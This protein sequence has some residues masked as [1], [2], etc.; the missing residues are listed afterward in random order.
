MAKFKLKISLERA[1]AVDD[2][3][4]EPGKAAKAFSRQLRITALSTILT[5]GMIVAVTVAW[6]AMNR[7]VST[8]GMQMDIETSSVDLV[9]AQTK[10]LLAANNV[11]NTTSFTPEANLTLS[12]AT[13]NWTGEGNTTG[14]KFFANTGYIDKYTGK[15]SALGASRLN[16]DDG[17]SIV[18]NAGNANNSSYYRV[19]DVWIGAKGGELEASSDMQWQLNA[20]L[21][22]TLSPD[23]VNHKQRDYQYAASVDF[24]ID[25]VSEAN[26]VGTLDLSHLDDDDPPEFGSSVNIYS[27]Y[28]GD[29]AVI[30]QNTDNSPIHVYMVF[31][32]DGALEQGSA[33]VPA[34]GTADAET[35]YYDEDGVEQTDIQEGDDVSELYIRQTVNYVRTFNISTHDISLLIRFEAVEERT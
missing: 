5:L 10:P 19:Y 25:S 15:V 7:D 24:Y 30:P 4:V 18:P 17:L 2:P 16:G 28:S 6:F 20:M 1:V 34:S 29:K 9:I 13:N 27:K 8:D 14:L 33:L 11:T 23:T 31:Y 35:T 12:P 3:A 26:Y 32:F 21:T 22:G